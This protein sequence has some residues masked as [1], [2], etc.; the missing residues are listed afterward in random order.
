[1]STEETPQPAAPP[2]AT[3]MSAEAVESAL[4]KAG[5]AANAAHEDQR[6]E[7]RMHVHWH[8][9]VLIDGR[10]VLSALVKDI[11]TRGAAVFFDS[12][13]RHVGKVKLRIHVPPESIEAGERMME[14]WGKAVYVAYDGNMGSFRMGVQFQHFV[15]SGDEVYLLRRAQ[16]FSK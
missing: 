6:A 16:L 12:N 14:I 5:K 1:M 15:S 2:F 8:A 7:P 11:S 3:E 9:E 13:V 10:R 4:H